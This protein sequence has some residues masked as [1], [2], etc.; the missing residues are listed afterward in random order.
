MIAHAESVLDCRNVAWSSRRAVREHRE[1]DIEMIIGM[2]SPGK[3]PFVA[4]LRDPHRAAH[5]PEM[6]VR[7]RDRDRL[8]LNGMAQL[9]PI[10]GDH[11]GRRRQAGRTAKL[12]HD[13]AHDENAL[14]LKRAQMR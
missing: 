12:R 3:S 9:A 11:V 6:R 13:F 5:G 10:G 4:K 8:E 14:R 7:Q 2:R 1:R